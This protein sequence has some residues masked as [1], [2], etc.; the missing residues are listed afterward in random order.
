MYYW[1][2]T[3]TYTHKSGGITHDT[4]T[5]VAS[6]ITAAMEGFMTSIRRRF[7]DGIENMAL[8]VDKGNLAR[9]L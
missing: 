2:F 9:A 8:D 1:T 3:Y 4:D 6:N 5:Y 7:P